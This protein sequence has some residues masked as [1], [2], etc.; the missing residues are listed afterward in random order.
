MTRIKLCG[1]TRPEDVL[2]ANRLAPDYVGFVFASGSRRCVSPAQAVRLKGLLSPGIRAVGVFVDQSPEDVAAL[3]EAGVIDLAQLHGSEGPDYLRALHRLTTKPV[4]QA[5]QVKA[6]TDLARAAD[7]PA[8]LV[9][10]DS[11]AGSGVSFDWNLLAAFPRPYLLAGGLDPANV[12]QAVRVLHPWG[13]DVS[14]GIETEGTKDP[15]KMAAFVA[16][17]RQEKDDMP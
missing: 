6:P 4:I 10:L 5:I 1:L 17:V 14:S 9:L 15:I 2:A 16:A 12:G 11:G 7:S 3:L 8:H 13:V